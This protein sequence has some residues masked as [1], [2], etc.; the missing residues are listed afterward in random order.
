MT[1]M[2]KSA[3][4]YTAAD[5]ALCFGLYQSNVKFVQLS[6][7]NFAGSTSTEF[8]IEKADGTLTAQGNKVKARSKTIKLKKP[9]KISA[10]KAYTIEGVIGD[11]A[12]SKVKASKKAGKFKVNETTGQ[13]KVKKGLKKGKYKLT[14]LISDAGDKNHEAAEAEAVVK[15]RIRK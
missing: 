2:K 9:K 7:G 12:F 4:V 13:I 6:L 10:E 8:T 15:I 1:Y 14:V 3:A 5:R 11:L